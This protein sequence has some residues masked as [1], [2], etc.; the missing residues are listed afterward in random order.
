M[1]GG[2]DPGSDAYQIVMSLYRYEQ[3]R[4]N[5]IKTRVR[6]AMAAQ[7]AIQGRFLGGHPPKPHMAPQCLTDGCQ[8]KPIPHTRF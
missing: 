1:G 5:R 3:R 2:I 4:R 6:T 8:S 7:A